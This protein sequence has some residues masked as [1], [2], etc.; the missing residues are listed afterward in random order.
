[1]RLSS[2]IAAAVLAAVPS[3]AAADPTTM[4][5]N[6]VNNYKA[7]HAFMGAVVAVVK[8]GNY[9]WYNFGWKDTST[10][11][12]VTTPIAI[13]S[14][15][16]TFVATSLA[17]SDTYGP[18][19]KST[20]LDAAFSMLVGSVP[21]HATLQDLVS[22]YSGLPR[23]AP[24]DPTTQTELFDS[25]DVC[26]WWTDP[27][28]APET[29]NVYSNYGFQVLGNIL[30]LYDGYATW[31]D[32]NDAQ[33]TGP[34][35]MTKT[36]TRGDGCHPSFSTSHAHAFDFAGNDISLPAHND[37]TDPEGGL[38]S[39]AEDMAVWM[40]YQLGLIPSTSPETTKLN[41]VLPLM[42]GKLP[43]GSGWSWQFKQLTFI[44]GTK[45]TIRFKLGRYKGL[46]S[47]TGLA[48]DRQ[49]GVFVFVNRDGT[50]PNIKDPSDAL[51]DDLGEKILEALP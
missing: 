1:M 27:C 29:K 8:G 39:T 47:Y 51:R 32:M 31:V 12:S 14:N 10:G 49:T 22:Y 36:C 50:D 16:K 21:A 5:T 24:S 25:L 48:D 40:R 20:E 41:A 2:A 15:T 23:D 28:F 30:S 42:K 44:D 9:Y 6:K 43:S 37:V 45:S 17:L 11:I 38:W 4:V 34:L 18:L 46:N 3:I 26:Q 7:S 13:A 19:P 35:G 33:I